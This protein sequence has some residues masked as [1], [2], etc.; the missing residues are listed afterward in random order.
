[1]I[2]L[3][4]TADK[5]QVITGQAVSTIYMHADYGEV[6][7]TTPTAPTEDYGVNNFSITGAQ[8]VDL[9]GVPTGAAYRRKVKYASI[10]NSHASSS[11]DITIQHLGAGITAQLY[12]HTL[13]AGEQIHYVEGVGFYVLDSTGVRGRWLRTTVINAGTTTFTTG[14][15]TNVIFVRGQAAG[16]AGGGSN[17]NATQAGIAGGGSAGGY[18][19][20]TFNVSPN[21]AYTCAVG[22]GGTGV[23]NATGNAGGNTTFTVGAT[24]ATSFGGNGGIGGVAQAN[25]SQISV[26]GGAPPAISTNGDINVSGEQGGVGHRAGPVFVA[27]GSIFSGQGGSSMFGTGG[28]SRNAVGTGNAGVGFGSGGGGSL[29]NAAAAQVGGAGTD[30]LLVVDEFS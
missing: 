26:L 24:T 5:F 17:G 23:S 1:M 15:E 3:V 16:G 12:K 6:N 8:T 22:T 25:T 4:G 2:F 18:F 19:E 27:T 30:G 7:L 14:A 10:R 13:L 21:T 29:A 11:C 28:Q 9:V 20:K